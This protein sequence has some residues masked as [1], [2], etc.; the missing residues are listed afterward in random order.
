[1]PSH[2]FEIDIW[3]GVV[4][5]TYD[6]PFLIRDQRSFRSNICSNTL[7]FFLEFLT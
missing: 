3:V 6:F 1:M 4:K 7:Q 5:A 2:L